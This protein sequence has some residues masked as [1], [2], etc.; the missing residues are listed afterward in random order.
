MPVI[1]R[2]IRPAVPLLAS[3]IVFLGL[4]LLL[5]AAQKSPFAPSSAMPGEHH[6]KTVLITQVVFTHNLGR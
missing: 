1:I 2:S 5:G 6:Y 3:L 4:E